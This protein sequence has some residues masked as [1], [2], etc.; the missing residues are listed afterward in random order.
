MKKKILIGIY[1]VILLI[2]GKLAFNYIY[3]AIVLYRYNQSDYSINVNPLL[4]F[5]LSEPYVAHYNQGNIY[6]KEDRFVDAIASYEKALE[7]NPPEEKE[8]AI[9]INLALAMLGTMGEEYATPE[10]ADTSLQ[11]LKEAREVLLEKECATENGNGHSNTAEQLKE[12]IEALIEKLEQQETGGEGTEESK[13]T[14]K[15]EETEEEQKQKEDAFEEDVKKT[16]Q[17]QQ[18]KANQERKKSLEFYKGIEEYNFDIEGNI[19]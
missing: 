2:C 12:E 16:L 15:D 8:C 5:N 10:N 14:E 3:N 7:L 11:I 19:W 17:E 18:S 4:T 1:I 13:E 9:R 6:Y